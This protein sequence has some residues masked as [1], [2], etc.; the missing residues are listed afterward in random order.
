MHD[1]MHAASRYQGRV[2]GLPGMGPW[3]FREGFQA[4][5]SSTINPVAVLEIG[6]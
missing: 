1:I 6:M 4:A 2:I 3:D 5:G